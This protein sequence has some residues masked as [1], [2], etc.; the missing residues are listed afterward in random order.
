MA[1]VFGWSLDVADGFEGAFPSREEAIEAAFK[2]AKEDHP[3][4][5]TSCEVV[6]AKQAEPEFPFRFDF[7]WEIERARDFLSD[8]HG[9]IE[10]AEKWPKLTRPQKDNIEEAVVCVIKEKLTLL[11]HWPPK[12]WV[13]VDQ[14]D[15]FVEQQEDGSLSIRKDP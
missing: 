5:W 3:G 6:T 12:F 13:A 9:I 11:G 1:D 2:Q 7:D 4:D 15:H 10:S 14:E 8:E